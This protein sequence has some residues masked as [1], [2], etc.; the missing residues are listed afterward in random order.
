MKALGDDRFQQQIGNCLGNLTLAYET[1]TMHRACGSG[2]DSDPRPTDYSV[3]TAWSR[4]SAQ[5]V[6]D[7]LTVV[8]SV[9]ITENHYELCNQDEVIAE[10]APLLQ[11]LMYD[12][13]YC[14]PTK[15]TFVLLLSDSENLI[16]RLPE[17]CF[18]IAKSTQTFYLSVV[19]AEIVRLFRHSNEETECDYVTIWNEQQLNERILD[20]IE[21][22]SKK[23]EVA[24]DNG[25]LRAKLLP[26]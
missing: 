4:T 25:T 2:Q 3:Y 20:A 24:M 22:V 16:S 14:S 12:V 11:P 7:A 10:L 23:G 19:L 5:P 8:I 21:L 15:F 26:I 6:L 1:A 18:P 17:M 9:P 13:K